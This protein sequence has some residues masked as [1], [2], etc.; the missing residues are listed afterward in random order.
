MKSIWLLILLTLALGCQT[1][2]T[3][4]YDP[5]KVYLAGEGIAKYHYYDGTSKCK[6]AFGL[7]PD[8]FDMQVTAV[9]MRIHDRFPAMTKV[10]KRGGPYDP[11][12]RCVRVTGVESGKTIKVR[13]IDKCCGGPLAS[14]G[15]HQ[16]DLA[17]EAFVQ[18]G[19][20]AKGNLRVKW[21]LIDCPPALQVVRASAVCDDG[22]Y[23]TR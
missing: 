11:K 12:A 13:A 17:E 10:G 20:K 15:T 23:F 4:G 6:T 5:K 7:D 9:S 3:A 14:K 8:A 22:Y 21:E 2:Q 1:T 19:P 18:L 16:L